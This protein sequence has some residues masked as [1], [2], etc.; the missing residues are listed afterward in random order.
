LSAVTLRGS[1]PPVTHWK[2]NGRSSGELGDGVAHL[3]RDPLVLLLVQGLEQLA[4][5]ARLRLRL[6]VGPQ[7]HLV[8]GQ[9]AAE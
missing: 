3:A 1:A 9:H 8:L 5:D 7:G 2:R 6:E 4:L